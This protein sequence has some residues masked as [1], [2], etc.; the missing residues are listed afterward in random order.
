M[1]HVLVHSTDYEEESMHM[2]LGYFFFYLGAL[3]SSYMEILLMHF[4]FTGLS[5][6]RCGFYFLFIHFVFDI[7]QMFLHS[8]S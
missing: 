2:I 4:I 8:C 6:E 7:S 1:S 5:N 3:F